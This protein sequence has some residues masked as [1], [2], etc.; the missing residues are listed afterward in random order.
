MPKKLVFTG[1][2]LDK[3]QNRAII[4]YKYNGQIMQVFYVYE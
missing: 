3:E 1:Y 4:F 2:E